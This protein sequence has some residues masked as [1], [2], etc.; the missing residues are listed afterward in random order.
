VTWTS[1]ISGSLAHIALR[2]TTNMTA[3]GLDAF[4]ACGLPFAYHPPSWQ[5]NS[6]SLHGSSLSLS[7]LHT[8][9]CQWLLVDIPALLYPACLPGFLLKSPRN[10]L[11][12]LIS[13]I[14]Q[15]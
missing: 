8:L 1:K 2:G 4:G 3:L 6:Q 15:T 13:C 9:T 10:P 5:L 14:L 11:W 12:H 7:K